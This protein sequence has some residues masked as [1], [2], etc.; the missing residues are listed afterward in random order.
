VSAI[1]TNS[2][3]ETVPNHPQLFLAQSPNAKR[4]V[5]NPKVRASVYAIY[6]PF[7]LQREAIVQRKLG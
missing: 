1:A 6:N 4:R 5:F 3:V 7:R 2:K